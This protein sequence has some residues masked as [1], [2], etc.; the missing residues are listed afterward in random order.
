MSR[1]I[2]G[3]KVMGEFEKP[4]NIICPF[5]LRK[6][7]ISLCRMV[8]SLTLAWLFLWKLG[9]RIFTLLFL[10]T[11]SSLLVK[12]IILVLPICLM[13][14]LTPTLLPTLRLKSSNVLVCKNLQLTL[15]L[16]CRL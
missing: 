7:V 3:T 4:I 14:C 6:V 2:L 9:K 10:S 15:T 1:L 8:G 16:Q 13:S 12:T 5:V 11:G